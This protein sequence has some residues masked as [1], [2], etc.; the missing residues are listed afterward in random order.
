MLLAAA[1]TNLLDTDKVM[2]AF[3]D[4]CFAAGPSNCA[5]YAS[6]P[7]AISQNL[8]QIYN[9]VASRPISVVSNT[10][11][12]YGVVDYNFVRTYVFLG[13][14]SPYASFA[15]LAQSLAALSKGDGRPF[16]DYVQST[17]TSSLLSQ[18]QMLET[19]IVCNDGNLIPGT[20]EDAEAYFN[21]LKQTSQFADVG[22]TIRLICS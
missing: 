15:P 10:T 2:Q 13:L 21:D 6:S 5:F 16:W 14:Y 19:G 1:R 17:G 11:N 3:F 12:T 22:A 7:E 4:G 20:V 9:N 8:Q 18:Q